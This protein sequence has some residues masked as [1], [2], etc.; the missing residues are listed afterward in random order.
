M[1]DGLKLSKWKAASP[2]SKTNAEEMEGNALSLSTA[3][4]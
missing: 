4:L 3:E 2:R 1:K